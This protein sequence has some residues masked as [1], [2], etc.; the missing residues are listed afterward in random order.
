MQYYRMVVFCHDFPMY[1]VDDYEYQD[2]DKG[3]LWK[4]YKEKM[5]S[6]EFRRIFQD[7]HS[8]RIREIGHLL[9]RYPP[10]KQVEMIMDG[11]EKR[12]HGQGFDKEVDD[13][14]WGLGESQD[15]PYKPKKIKTKRKK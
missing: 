1:F 8:M 9:D 10:H 3:T 6:P 4:E 14:L 12:L 11:M 15:K 7:H 13:M 2:K 5:I